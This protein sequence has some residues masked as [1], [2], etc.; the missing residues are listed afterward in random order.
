MS[1]RDLKRKQFMKASLIFVVIAVLLSDR[2]P[3]ANE[4]QDIGAL[5][6]L[7]QAY[8]SEWETGDADG[9][10]ALFTVGRGFTLGLLI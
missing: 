10:M 1:V 8:A 9:V 5:V 6:A 4:E 3:H 7:D 2:S